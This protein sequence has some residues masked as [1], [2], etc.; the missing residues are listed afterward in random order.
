L[1][2]PANP[3]VSPWATGLRASGAD[4]ANRF[5]KHALAILLDANYINWFGGFEMKRI[6]GDIFGILALLS[7]LCLVLGGI[8]LVV[9]ATANLHY[10]DLADRILSFAAPTCDMGIVGIGLFALLNKLMQDKD[11]K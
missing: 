4:R 10:G 2:L 7:L 6:I 1:F 11:K 5:C 3:T 9:G 8:G